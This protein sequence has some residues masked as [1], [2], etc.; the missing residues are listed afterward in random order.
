MGLGHYNKVMR[1][2]SLTILVLFFDLSSAERVAAPLNQ[3]YERALAP[4]TN[5][6]QDARLRSSL[7]RSEG[8]SSRSKLR[9]PDKDGFVY[10]ADPHNSN[11]WV[12]NRYIETVK[13]LSAKRPGKKCLFL[14]QDT[15]PLQAT[16]DACNKMA[17]RRKSGFLGTERS[18]SGFHQLRCPGRKPTFIANGPTIEAALKNGWD[19]FAVDAHLTKCA[20][21]QPIL[22]KIKCRNEHMAEAISAQ[23]KN[24]CK[25][26]I[27][28]NGSAHLDTEILKGSTT[29]ELVAA[30]GGATLAV[31]QVINK[32]S[33]PLNPSCNLDWNFLS[34]YQGSVQSADLNSLHPIHKNRISFPGS[35]DTLV[36]QD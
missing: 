29:Q 15:I 23:M 18:L 24:G 10:F 2:I 25:S 7:L 8:Q 35:T 30:K 19:V 33:I 5:C 13:N 14:E 11:V 1:L 12:E 20:G 26:G 17:N 4:S 9:Y 22:D 34:T 3:T 27:V 16:L 6:E 32:A 28:I 36:G 31:V 21:D